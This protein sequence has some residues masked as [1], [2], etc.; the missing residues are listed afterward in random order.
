MQYTQKQ[1]AAIGERGKNILVSAAAGSGKTSV[2]SERIAR[3]V[4]QGAD[5]KNMLVCTFTNLAAGEM[6][7]RIYRRLMELAEQKEDPRLYAQAERALQA[8]ICTIHKFAISVIQQNLLL[9]DLKT[10]V[11]IAVG[12]EVD[13]LKAQA[14]E[15]ALEEL[16]ERQEE[17][18][19]Q[20]YAKYCKKDDRPIVQMAMQIYNFIMSKEH[21]LEWLEQAQQLSPQTQ[22]EYFG[23]YRSHVV[24]I[25]YRAKGDFEQSLALSSKKGYDAQRQIDEAHLALTEGWLELARQG[26]FDALKSQLGSA[27][28][29]P[30]A[31]G[32]PEEADK[33]K[34]SGWKSDAKKQVDSLQNLMTEQELLEQIKGDY[35]EVKGDICGLT[36]IIHG[37]HEA[38]QKLKREKNIIDYDDMLHIAYQI[39][40]SG[41]GNFDVAKSYQQ[42]YDYIFVDEYQDTN[43]IQEA[44]LQAISRGNNMF[45]VGDMKQSIYKFRLADPSIFLGKAKQYGTGEGQSKLINMNENFRCSKSV[46]D[47]INGLMGKVMSP[48]VGEISYGVEEALVWSGREKGACKLS[49]ALGKRGALKEETEAALIAGEIKA[50]LG[51]DFFDEKRGETRPLA[52]GDF[53]IIM[54]TANRHGEVYKRV[55]QQQGIPVRTLFEAQEDDPYIEVF[56]NLL[57]LV[58]N[59]YRDIE[60]LSVMRS[61][62]GGFDERDFAQIRLVDGEKTFAQTFFSNDSFGDP[63]L[64]QKA[65]KLKN[66]LS[67]FSLYAQT[68]PVK[69]TLLK[70]KTLTHF[71]AYLCALPGGAV[72]LAAFDSFIKMCLSINDDRIENFY[73]FIE[74]LQEYKKNIG[75]YVETVQLEEE[76]DAV[77]ILT[78]HASKGL[79]F[80]VVFV[81]RLQGKY[82]TRDF[83]KELLVHDTMGIG[84]KWK[85]VQRHVAKDTWQRKLIAMRLTQELKSESL[86]VLYVALTRARHTLILTG[87]VDQL[88]DE[89]RYGR[90]LSEEA[91]LSMNNWLDLVLRWGWGENQLG[92]DGLLPLEM[93]GEELGGEIAEEKVSSNI[94]ILKKAAEESQ[95][96]AL[97]KITF[98]KVPRTMTV[99]ELK[100]SMQTRHWL[101]KSGDMTMDSRREDAMDAKEL[102]PV[103]QWSVQE[104]QRSQDVLE[105]QSAAHGVGWSATQRGSGLHRVLEV[106]NFADQDIPMQIEKLWK[107]GKITSLERDIARKELPLLEWFLHSDMARRIAS[108]KKVLRE[109]P[110]KLWDVASSFG[111]ESHDK[112]IVQGVIDLAFWEQGEI[113][114][115]D[116]KTDRVGQEALAERVAYYR[117]QVEYYAK[118]LQEITGCRVKEKHLNFISCKKLVHLE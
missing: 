89:I 88:P 68:L 23:A 79:E 81:S 80:P 25:L 109:Q 96:D 3:L 42:K 112:I 19:S 7:E 33:K 45:M 70:I 22:E 105:E 50:L 98:V 71:D 8:D 111:Y 1:Q 12:K 110:F 56:V 17:G 78:V 116:H 21:P 24:Q 28:F 87:V 31:R 86:R 108:S 76:R 20:L 47:F 97:A 69:E 35:E 5:I 46:V 113:I 103:P 37:F 100:Q 40:S 34:L 44:I 82:N 114:L 26:E 117:P 101:I 66:T 93:Q 107:A 90:P 61:F 60:L 51:K 106:W 85:D 36:S 52:F 57:R 84:I 83:D 65:A 74:F 91:V 16:C 30:I 54:R 67:E 62:I 77:R 6:K 27:K 104:E 58:D 115:L 49:L 59:P 39:L 11:R 118:A 2:L 10:N 43:G 92:P 48:Q 41:E 13:I 14:M 55:L 64:D 18:V 102:W 63:V 75:K 29:R 9:T 38:F 73:A 94:N 95:A 4:E 32:I 72:R 99:S 15:Q 53:C